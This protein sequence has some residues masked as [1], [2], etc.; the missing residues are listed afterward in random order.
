MNTCGLI[1]I[2]GSNLYNLQLLTDLLENDG[3]EVIGVSTVDDLDR[4]LC[5]GDRIGL[6]LVDISGFDCS[7]WHRCQRLQQMDVPLLMISPHLTPAIQR[8]GLECGARSILVKPLVK[9]ELLGLIRSLFG[10]GDRHGP[11][12]K[13]P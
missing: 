5:S 10:Q 11:D 2:V 6:A 13:M 8:L 7:I 9:A 12:Y 4:V 3:H 1:L